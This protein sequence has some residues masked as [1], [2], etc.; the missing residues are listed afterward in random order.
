MRNARLRSPS[1]SRNR[2]SRLRAP[3]GRSFVCAVALASVA[4][5]RAPHSP[6]TDV[7]GVGVNVNA[8][9][10]DARLASFAH[11]L[12]DGPNAGH[13][14][15]EVLQRLALVR[16]EPANPLCELALMLAARNSDDMADPWAYARELAGLQPNGLDAP[17]RARLAR[18]QTEERLARLAPAELERAARSDAFPDYSSSV[19]ILAPLEG[20]NPP[21]EWGAIASAPESVQLCGLRGCDVRWQS[22]RRGNLSA[23]IQPA[24]WVEP[25]EGCALVCFELDHPRG[26]AGYLEIDTS[27][28]YAAREIDNLAARDRAWSSAAGDPTWWWSLDGAPARK[29]DPFDDTRPRLVREPV[30]F[31]AGRNRALIFCRLDSYPTFAVRVLDPHG[32]VVETKASGAMDEAT[33]LGR[34]PATDARAPAAFVDAEARLRRADATDDERALLGLFLCLD[35]RAAEGLELLRQ[36]ASNAPERAGLRA[37]YAHQLV[38]APHL[39]DI[40]KRAHARQAFEAVAQSSGRPDVDLEL[41][42]TLVLEDHE[43]DAIARLEQA[44][45]LA[46]ESPDAWLELARVYPRLEM[47]LAAEQ[48]LAHALEIAPAAPAALKSALDDIAEEGLPTRSAAL[49]RRWIQSR[50]AYGDGWKALSDAL[51]AS[52]DVDGSWRALACARLRGGHDAFE[53]AAV[54]FLVERGRDAEADAIL[55][56]LEREYPRWSDPPLERAALARTRQDGAGEREHLLEALRRSPGSSEARARFAALDGH[57]RTA[58]LFAR[59]RADRDDVLASYDERRWDDSVVRVL[60]S[61]VVRVFADGSQSVLTHEILQVKDLDGCKR[62]GT[63]RPDGRV[64]K[65]VT[66]KASDRRELEP[67]E[68]DGEYVMPALKPGDWVERVFTNDIAAPERGLKGL[69]SWRFA[70]S[71]EPFHVSRYVVI[72]PRSMAFDLVQRNFD[73]THEIVEDGDDVIHVFELDDRDRLQPEPSMPP[74]NW[75]LPWVQWGLRQDA[76]TEA[77]RELFQ[78]ARLATRVT[79]ELTEVVRRS[80]DGLPS[81]AARAIA[82]YDHVRHTIKQ[83]NMRSSLSATASLLSEEGNPAYLFAALLDAAHIRHTLAWSRDVAPEADPENDPRGAA[84]FPDPGRWFHR[85]LVRVEPQ[86]ANAAWCDLSVRDLP[87]GRLLG[88]AP[89]AEVLT[90]EGLARLPELALEERIGSRFTLSFDIQD[91]LSAKVSARI[92]TTGNGGYAGKDRFK[93]IPKAQRGATL[94]R[95]FGQI[96]PRF[97]LESFETPG[98]DDEEPLALVAAGQVKSFIDRLGDELTLK[99]PVP[100]LTLSAGLVG[101]EGER[102]LPYFLRIS[103]VSRAEV[104]LTLPEGLRL[105]DGPP[106]TEETFELGATDAPAPRYVLTITPEGEHTLVLRR[107]LLVP[108]FQLAASEYPRWAQFCAH[109]DEVERVPLRFTK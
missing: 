35:E 79:P 101:G 66:I 102:K 10:D 51:A 85:L 63:Q 67:V 54:D 41:A 52:G 31:H 73:D 8:G 77:R 90:P 89:R 21:S 5:A 64:E 17:A 4:L 50:G 103:I 43:E 55:A 56:R 28:S 36:A 11:A 34:A 62:Q 19:R 75:I 105:A 32:E 82:L 18:L 109:V 104:R 13:T 38:A 91:D 70:S 106:R 20:P 16:D 9:V 29:V 65:L 53:R 74:E 107:D 94:T 46:P 58:E 6:F 69:G 57:E 97:D 48:A 98:L 24:D 22:A 92:D 88:N 27:G 72:L 99:L 25:V 2:S 12:V 14:D 45:A 26:G 61:Q 84:P 1:S 3:S 40:W 76:E 44:K 78:E 59:W 108:P 71:V 39:P 93:E 60:D 47:Q 96:V 68:V 30:V 15:A 37:L 100:A 95:V 86:G 81:E 87:Y 42:R 49:R 7:E 23:Q 80:T 33:P 83:P